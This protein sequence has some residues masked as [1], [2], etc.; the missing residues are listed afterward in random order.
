VNHSKKF[1]PFKWTLALCCLALTGALALA[2]TPT[3]KPPCATQPGYA[4]VPA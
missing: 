4:F 1:L 2:K 3:T